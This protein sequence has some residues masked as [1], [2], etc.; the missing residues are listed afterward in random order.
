MDVF[1][2]LRREEWAALRREGRL[3][4]APVDLADGFVHLSTAAQLRETAARH[5]AGAED[6]FL[7]S[8]PSDRLGAD[9]RWEASRGG[10]D[11]PH[12]YRELR[13]SDVEWA[14]PLP[15]GPEGHGFPEGID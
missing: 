15:L 8:V 2:I 10:A 12:L 6:L 9:L 4:G 13:L 1:K 7:L 5:F 14:Q 3:A 11:F